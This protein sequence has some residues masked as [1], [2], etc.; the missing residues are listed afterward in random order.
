MSWTPDLTTQQVIAELIETLFSTAPEV[1]GIDEI[2]SGCIV[3]NM[4][5]YA[6]GALPR[7]IRV[8]LRDREHQDV[9]YRGNIPGLAPADV[10]TVIHFRDGNRYEVLSAGGATGIIDPGAPLDAEYVTMALDADLTDERVL[11]VGD[12]LALTDGGAGG[13]ATISLLFDNVVL[14][15][16]V[17]GSITE[18]ATIQLAINAVAAHDQIILIPAGTYNEN[19][20]TGATYRMHFVAW[21]HLGPSPITIN[22]FAVRIIGNHT[23]E[24]LTYWHGIYF[25]GN[26]TMNGLNASTS[27][28]NCYLHG[29][30]ID[31]GVEGDLLVQTSYIDGDISAANLTI[32]NGHITGSRTTT[33]STV[34]RG[35]VHWAEDSG[36][37]DG[38]DWDDLTP[39]LFDE[40]GLLLLNN[41][42]DIWLK[43]AIYRWMTSRHDYA[44]VTGAIHWE[45]GAWLDTRGLV[46]EEATT[47]L[48]PNP[49]F[50]IDLTG[51]GTAGGDLAARSTDFARFGEASIRLTENGG[52]KYIRY[53]NIVTGAPIPQGNDYTA[54]GWVRGVAGQQV[55]FRILETGG[56]AGAAGVYGD[57][58]TL[59]GGWQRIPALTWT[60][61]QADR[62]GL[63][64]YIY[65]DYAAGEIAYFDGIQL[66]LQDYHTSYCDGSLGTGYAWTGAAHLSTS[67]RTKTEV[68]LDDYTGLINDNSTLTFSFWVQALYDADGVWPQAVSNYLFGTW[69]AAAPGSNFI[70]GYYH[71][72]PD[73]FYL[74][75]DVG[76]VG[77]KTL[78]S[79][80]QTFKAGDW[81]HLV[82]TIDFAADTMIV[83]VDGIESNDYT[84]LTYAAPTLLDKWNLGT[85]LAQGHQAGFNFAE[86][87]VFDRVLT[88]NEVKILASARR[89]LVDS[90]GTFKS[91]APLAYYI[92]VDNEIIY[93]KTPTGMLAVQESAAATVT[94]LVYRNAGQAV[95]GGAN[96]AL[97]LT[98]EIFDIGNNWV[99]GAPTRFTPST[100]GYYMV[101]ANVQWLDT[102]A[103]D[104]V[105]LWL[106]KNL[107]HI[108]AWTKDDATGTYFGMNVGGLIYLNGTGDFIEAYVTNHGGVLRNIRAAGANTTAYNSVWIAKVG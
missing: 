4:D 65:T 18:Y 78:I 24:Y 59:T 71:P 108:F 76:N 9:F 84:A 22:D 32:F 14:F 2:I 41:D 103:G 30:V 57:W 36:T 82:W 88:A 44:T 26:I 39:F 93:Y 12:W 91:V 27:L 58:L 72:T 68:D 86:F 6:V 97:S 37:L 50:E 42:S 20:T 16:V 63:N 40:E 66:E 8:S 34:W 53:T 104:D 98:T 69:Q 67:T 11:T 87:A 52:S 102:A 3:Q 15:D 83:Y 55:H 1:L 43:D 62:T 51:W 81:I 49:S 89:P 107:A 94:A 35:E 77:T 38:I 33:G 70:V 92:D 21:P 45:H 23:I 31:G 28:S 17:T 56:A 75:I 99:G 100:S 106:M 46:I 29:D 73:Q 10:V 19:L 95:G 25:D 90:L 74:S 54:T 47:N 85:D 96:A 7:Y 105:S 64:L 61:V 5:P 80:A 60:I 48:C 13:N 79:A 101:G